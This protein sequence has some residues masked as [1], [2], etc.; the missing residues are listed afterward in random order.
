M[1]AQVTQGVGRSWP[2]GLRSARGHTLPCSSHNQGATCH[3]RCASDGPCRWTCRLQHTAIAPLRCMRHL[4][5]LA[6]KPASLARRPLRSA[7]RPPHS[8]RRLLSSAHRPLTAARQAGGLCARPDPRGAPV[9]KA[10]APLNL[11]GVPHL[12]NLACKPERP[13]HRLFRPAC[14]ALQPR[15]R[16]ELRGAPSDSGQGPLSG[17]CASV[18]HLPPRET[19][20]EQ[21]AS[22]PAYPAHGAHR[23]GEQS[24]Q[25]VPPRPA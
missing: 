22:R 17:A 1:P 19:R 15:A 23:R 6:R 12:G 9:A 25:A 13:A 2:G 4:W 24:P 18:A 3:R 7:C 11:G 8:A 10:G 14:Q 20:P 5:G 21:P 16:P